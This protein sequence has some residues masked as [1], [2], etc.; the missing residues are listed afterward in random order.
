MSRKRKAEI[1]C[2]SCS[3]FSSN[4]D[5]NELVVNPI[6]NAVTWEQYQE[7]NVDKLQLMLRDCC[8]LPEVLVP[9]CG[10]Y[11]KG[12]HLVNVQWDYLIP[13]P[14][15]TPDVH[16][17]KVAVA[18]FE[19]SLKLPIGR[20]FLQH[21]VSIRDRSRE[22][23]RYQLICTDSPT[24]EKMTDPTLTNQY[25]LFVNSV[26]CILNQALEK[27]PIR[28]EY[29]R[30]FS[31][32][33]LSNKWTPLPPFYDPLHFFGQCGEWFPNG[34]T[35]VSTPVSPLHDLIFER[36]GRWILSSALILKT[37]Q[38]NL[39]CASG[40]QTRY[41]YPRQPKLELGSCRW[42]YHIYQLEDVVKLVRMCQRCHSQRHEQQMATYFCKRDRVGSCWNNDSPTEYLCLDCTH[43]LVQ[44]HVRE[45][46]DFHLL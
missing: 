6:S 20:M 27:D 7:W 39:K 9:L 5:D 33:K 30:V 1:K 19:P 13:Q 28:M 15:G 10:D 2:H 40:T 21:I 18:R 4:D 22:P 44:S 31:E 32:L 14:I 12:T 29:G 3:D 11:L 37:V 42:Y 35:D 36:T 8:D 43:T 16:R 25:H 38:I 24:S 34:I 17:T 46:S 45:H 26:T 41:P 23:S